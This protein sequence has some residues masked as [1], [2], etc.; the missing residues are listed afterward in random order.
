MASLLISVLDHLVIENC[1]LLFPLFT[2]EIHESQS[3][4]EIPIRC[5][6]Y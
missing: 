6:Y 2:E 4:F 3:L 5:Y 1:I